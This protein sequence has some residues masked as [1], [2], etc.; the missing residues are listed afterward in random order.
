MSKGSDMPQSSPVITDSKLEV[1]ESYRVLKEIQRCIEKVRQE[2]D[3]KTLQT[4]DPQ[5]H[6]AEQTL[7]KYARELASFKH[8]NDQIMICYVSV[9]GHSGIGFFPGGRV[10]AYRAIQPRVER[11]R[12][13][14]DLQAGSLKKVGRN[15]IQQLNKLDQVIFP[16]AAKADGVFGLLRVVIRRTTEKVNDLLSVIDDA[17]KVLAA[18][19]AKRPEQKER[20]EDVI[21][22]RP[23][24]S[25]ISCR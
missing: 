14:Q 7:E 23:I 19:F 25:P 24:P 9:M 6:A 15:L 10:D 8:T 12:Q 1:L 3:Q 11:L 21:E 20:E 4:I 5:L 18:K 22:M 17:L 16:Y 13:R 2:A